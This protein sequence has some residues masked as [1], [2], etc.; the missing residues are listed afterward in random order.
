MLT[1]ADHRELLD[2]VVSLKGC[3]VVSGRPHRLYGTVLADWTCHQTGQEDF[4]W[5]NR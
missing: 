2:L 1:D 4:V 3:V 5:I